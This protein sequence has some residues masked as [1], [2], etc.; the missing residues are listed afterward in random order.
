MPEDIN[1]IFRLDGNQ[2]CCFYDDFIDLQQSSAGYGD[3]P[4]VALVDLIQTEN[5]F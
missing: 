1:I 5:R 4:D 2:W 3:T